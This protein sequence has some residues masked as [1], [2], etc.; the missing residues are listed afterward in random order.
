MIYLKHITEKQ[1]ILVPKGR[2]VNAQEVFFE[3]SNDFY[4][5]TLRAVLNKKNELYYE[6]VIELPQD[7]QHGEYEYSFSDEVGEF[8]SGVFVMVSDKEAST[9]YHLS[10][11]YEQ[12]QIPYSC[13]QH[14][15]GQEYRQHETAYLN[16]QY[17]VDHEFAQ[18]VIQY[19]FGQNVLEHEY[20]QL[21]TE[22]QQEQHIIN[23]DFTQHII[24]HKFEEYW[25]DS[26]F[27]IDVLPDVIWLFPD[28][29]S[30]VVS[31]K[32]NVEW[33]IK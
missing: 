5:E 22:Y 4:H 13:E 8:S 12:C 3:V 7:I 6:V 9:E 27:F 21:V 14:I 20:K 1:K 33:V 23:H 26:R 32:S 2:D 10:H 16:E 31:V 28:N 15:V 25:W 19:D 24:E 17:I 18:H 11:K 29:Y 30:A